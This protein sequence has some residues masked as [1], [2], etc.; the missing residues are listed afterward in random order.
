MCFIIFTDSKLY[1]YK[2]IKRCI[3][4]SFVWI[5]W[6]W[7]EGKKKDTN[8]YKWCWDS[9]PSIFISFA[10]SS[11]LWEKFNRAPKHSYHVSWYNMQSQWP[12]DKIKI[13]KFRF[14]YLLHIRCQRPNYWN[15]DISDH[16]W[17]IYNF[18]VWFYKKYTIQKSN[19][20]LWPG[21]QLNYSRLNYY[22]SPKSIYW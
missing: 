19:S 22:F 11:F 21:C 18:H 2:F 6:H 14:K 8:T 15:P 13:F 10:V 3:E 4:E 7:F 16:T 17:S 20:K 9:L 12:F 1:W 5:F